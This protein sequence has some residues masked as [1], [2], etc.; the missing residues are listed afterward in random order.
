MDISEQL[1]T[2]TNTTTAENKRFWFSKACL[3]GETIP[4]FHTSANHS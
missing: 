2:T 1:G 3:G 4:S